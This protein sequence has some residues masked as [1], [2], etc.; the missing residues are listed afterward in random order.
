[1]G[2]TDEAVA[3]LKE[4]IK[5]I[6]PDKNLFSLYQSCAEILARAGKTDDAVSL[7]REGIKVP[8]ITSLFS[9]YQ[10]SADLLAK[11]GKTDEAVAL[12][13]EGI[14]VIPPDLGLSALFERM[15][16]VLCRAGHI[17][18]AI[19]A[20]REGMKLVPAARGGYRLAEAALLLA[21]G[22]ND[23][24][25]FREATAEL[26]ATRAMK[27]QEF[28][29]EVLAHEGA[30]DWSQA[31]Q[32]AAK[33]RVQVPSYFA[34]GLHESLCHLAQ[35]DSEG[36]LLSLPVFPS[37][38]VKQGQT[39]WWLAAFIHLRR[40]AR[41]E[42]SA[43]LAA[44]LGRAADESREL[45][46]AFLLRAWDQQEVASED[47]RLCFHFPIMPASLTG[48]SQ[49]VRR[50]PF[51]KPVLPVQAAGAPVGVV[52]VLPVAHSDEPEV[53]VSYA[54]GDDKMPEGIARE[55]V[56]NQMCDAV[57]RTG[58]VVG[59]DKTVMKPGDSI[60]AFADKIAKAPRIVA[61]ISAKSLHS[62]FCMVDEIYSAYQRCG[63]RRDE[64]RLKVIALVMDDA[65]PLIHEDIALVKHWKAV[66]EKE[67]TELLDVDAER[68]ELERWAKV[69]KLGEMCERLLGM[70][71]AI[72]D[73][74]MPRGY[75]N[76]VAGN[77]QEVIGRLPPKRN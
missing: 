54:W 34:L 66:H 37:E 67:R 1:V 72:K 51:G 26:T 61:V 11:V 68:K 38:G 21:V 63:F 64:F 77:F 7:L 27:P 33:A 57:G 17:S 36:A 18:D 73:T 9:L 35:G 46:E 56:V 53:Y 13:K 29:S 47:G 76:I 22:S 23:T 74:I 6:P 50:V 3:L 70:L 41:P 20:Q 25:Q 16:G 30:G 52:A 8:G 49:P 65:K 71:D 5:V 55:E 45:N 58:R 42:A 60:D 59:R 12:L 28:L 15:S 43:A 39:R 62:K 44:Y 2:K 4:G 31:L 14:K 19:A 75:E 48:L 69:H 40:A 10:I 24:T 32:S